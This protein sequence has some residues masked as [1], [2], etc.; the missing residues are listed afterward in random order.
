[1]AKPFYAKANPVVIHDPALFTEVNRY[2][3]EGTR[4]GRTGATFV[5][6]KVKEAWN[7]AK[8]RIPKFVR[9]G[10]VI[11]E[12]TGNLWGTLGDRLS[13]PLPLTHLH[14]L[15]VKI[16]DMATAMET[17]LKTGAHYRESDYNELMAL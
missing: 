7:E 6:K 8:V 10:N 4:K 9:E 12:A 17:N 3:K 5:G 2:L 11:N 16:G 13:G 15:Q 1:M 14:T